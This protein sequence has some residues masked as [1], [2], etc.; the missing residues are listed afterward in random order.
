MTQKIWTV[1]V[2]NN[3][4]EPEVFEQVSARKKIGQVEDYL[5]DVWEHLFETDNPDT[6]IDEYELRT[7]LVRKSG[8]EVCLDKAPYV[9]R[10]VLE[11]N[12]NI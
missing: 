9:L 4:A 6:D 5:C 2:A 3:G 1:T 10:A 12:E 11:T 7:H 8:T